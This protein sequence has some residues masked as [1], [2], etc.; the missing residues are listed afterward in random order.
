MGIGSSKTVGRPGRAE[1]EAAAARIRDVVVHT[2]LV[3][4]DAPL[5]A[6]EILLKPEVLQPTGSFKVRGVYHAVLRLG[7]EA[8]ARGLSTVSAGN[9]AKALAWCARRF[10]V[11]ARS[12]MPAGAPR[13]KIDAVRALG[14]TPVLVPTA[15]VFRY[16]RERGWES[17]P[18]V[19]VDPWTDRDV[20]LGHGSLGLEILSDRPDVDTVYVPVGGG[21][22]LAGVASALKAVRPAV[23][24]VAVEP[25]GCPSFHAAL[26]AG[27]PVTVACDTL[28]DGVAVPYVTAEMFPLLSEL[29]DEVVLVSEDEVRAAIRLLARA[30]HLVAEGAGAL[31]TAAALKT[32]PA[33]RGRA[34]CLVTGGSIDLPK[35][36]AILSS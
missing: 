29:A 35:L 6:R 27:A 10:G 24:V 5:E 7:D 13:T 19:F 17:E 11:A 1:L 20:I 28:C 21:G 36:A 2:P 16:L 32:P 25:A 22:L 8:R 18:H 4:L 31:A 26:R 30:N 12:L 3:P 33:E 23:R 34:V 15:E 14:A 9:T